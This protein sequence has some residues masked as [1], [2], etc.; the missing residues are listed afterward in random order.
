M[1]RGV[2]H[3]HQTARFLKRPDDFNPAHTLEFP[4]APLDR[5]RPA[6]ED[7]GNT[8]EEFYMLRPLAL[9]PLLIVSGLSVAGFSALSQDAPQS[10]T[11]VPV[12]APAYAIPLDAA[13]KA[14][15]VKPT[16]ASL[17]RAKQI[18]GYDCAL[19]HGEKG[20]GKG[21]LAGDMK[22]KMLDYRDPASLKGMTDGELFYIIYKGKGQ[23]TPEEGRAKPDEVWNLVLYLRSMSKS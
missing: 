16:T 9:L 18:Y 3:R 8:L 13:Q 21:D 1:I 4:A 5:L 20:D 2:P 6:V 14:N 7:T 19:C 15:P 10:S 23:M 17:A 22:A 11:P 12:P